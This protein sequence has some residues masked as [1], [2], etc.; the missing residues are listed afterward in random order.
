MYPVLHLKILSGLRG[1][2]VRQGGIPAHNGR[3]GVSGSRVGY[4][5]IPCNNGGDER[6]T[7]DAALDSCRIR[8]GRALYLCENHV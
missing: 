6:K 7:G 8:G 5:F 4:L 1:G 2:P 3:P